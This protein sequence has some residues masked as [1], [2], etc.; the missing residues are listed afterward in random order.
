MESELPQ[1]TSTPKS[2]KK[3]DETVETARET[4]DQMQST[5]CSGDQA[6]TPKKNGAMEGLRKFNR[7]FVP[8]TKYGGVHYSTEYKNR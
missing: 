7:Q 4:V 8:V 5:S 6:D 2:E 3:I 1:K